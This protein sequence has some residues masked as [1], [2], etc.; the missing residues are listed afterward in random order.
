MILENYEAVPQEQTVFC[1]FRH[2]G[3]MKEH[4]WAEGAEEKR[5][6]Q[7]SGGFFHGHLNRISLIKL[8]KTAAIV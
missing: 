3:R 8:M 6:N 5:R 4:E 2:I 7:G 1:A